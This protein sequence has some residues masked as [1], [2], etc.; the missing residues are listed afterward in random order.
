MDAVVCGCLTPVNSP[1]TQPELLYGFST[2]TPRASLTIRLPN[3]VRGLTAASHEL[4]AGATIRR[5]FTAPTPIVPDNTRLR[6]K[7]ACAF[8]FPTEA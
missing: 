6:L 5:G 1:T 8:Q 7:C 2:R 3:G 4:P